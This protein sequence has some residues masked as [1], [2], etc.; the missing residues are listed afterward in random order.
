MPHLWRRTQ[1]LELTPQEE[2]ELAVRVEAAV[3]ASRALQGC[4][5]AR[6]CA[7]CQPIGTHHVRLMPGGDSC[8]SGSC[9]QQQL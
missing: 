1:E 4:V 2:E 8:R 5:L 7:P 9:C 6:C 3:Q